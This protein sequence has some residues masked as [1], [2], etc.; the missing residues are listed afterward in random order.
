M[1]SATFS[2]CVPHSRF[3]FLSSDWIPFRCRTTFFSGLF[4]WNASH[5][6]Q[7]TFF[8]VCLPAHRVTCL[9]P[10]L[11]AHVLSVLGSVGVGP[12]PLNFFHE[13]TCPR[14][15]TSYPSKPWTG[16]HSSIAPFAISLCPLLSNTL[17][18]AARISRFLRSESAY[19]NR[20]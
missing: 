15:D 7:Q 10:S 5:T 14:D 19:R 12:L 17:R 13:R 1:E 18:D 20:L 16:R 8:V 9:Y 6:S 2:L 11:S 3:S 4:P